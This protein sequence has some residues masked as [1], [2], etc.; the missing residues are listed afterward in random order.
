MNKESETTQEIVW[1]KDKAGNL[2]MCPIDA[3]E[4]PENPTEEELGKC[5]MVDP[6]LF[7]KKP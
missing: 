7:E 2:Y 6:D 4:D 5:T 3:L 1:V